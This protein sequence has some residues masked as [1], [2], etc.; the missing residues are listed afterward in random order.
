VVAQGG[1]MAYLVGQAA[2]ALMSLALQT[3]AVEVAVGLA[4]GL[5]VALAV[6]AL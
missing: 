3:Q 2:V 6:L 1:I 4:L 5:L